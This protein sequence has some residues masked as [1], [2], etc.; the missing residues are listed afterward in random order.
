MRVSTAGESSGVIERLGNVGTLMSLTILVA[1]ELHFFL[2]GAVSADAL[3]TGSSEATAIA[4]PAF[5]DRAKKLRREN[6][7]A[8]SFMRRKPTLP[9]H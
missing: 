4:I 7:G 1:S 3:R 5:A 6:W 9:V 8:L 2:L